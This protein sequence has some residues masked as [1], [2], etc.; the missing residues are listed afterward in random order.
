MGDRSALLVIHTGR[1]N[2][3]ELA[4]LVAAD[5]VA[6]DFEVR[7]VADEAAGVDLPGVV[8]VSGPEAAE[9]VEMVFALGGDGT[10]LRAAELARPA[11][12]PLL[13]INLGKV[14]FLAE[15]EVD[16][17]DKVVEHVIAREYTVDSRLT[18]DVCIA[19]EGE[20]VVE[21]WALNEAS[22]EKGSRERMIELRVDVD[23][24]PLSRY[25]CDG[26]VCA[27]PT[28]STAYAFSAGGPVVWP[29]VEALLLVPIS[30][31][32]LFSRAVV[33]A[34]SSTITITLDPHAAPGVMWCDGRRAF[35]VPPGS[36]ITV[37][38]GS[39]P[40]KVARLR[41]RPFTDRL[42]AKFGLP[43]AGWRS[44]AHG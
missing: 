36:Q 28:G 42:V 29:E 3:V 38:R 43:V 27:T 41:H 15:A 5:L 25:G 24:R 6:A 34:P 31:H 37:R 20:V 9:G 10:L 16:D 8:G 4:Q 32:A 13:G 26:V 23:G 2:S 21:S 14:G 1:P 18:V 33:T 11:M 7:V 22:V 44:N 30:A 40:V 12:V 19:H 39:L 35:D 17:I